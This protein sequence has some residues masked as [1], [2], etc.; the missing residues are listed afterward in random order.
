MVSSKQKNK[1]GDWHQF[2]EQHLKEI[3]PRNKNGRIWKLQKKEIRIQM[4]PVW[5]C[6]FHNITAISDTES[7]KLRF[8]HH[9]RGSFAALEEVQYTLLSR[10]LNHSEICTN[11]QQAMKPGNLGT[12]LDTSLQK[13]LNMFPQ[14][15]ITL[16]LPPSQAY[17][18][19]TFA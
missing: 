14:W 7:N 2:P 1:M 8:P 13:D 16:Q 12:F 17:Q 6:I 18:S 9:S 19:H 3:I 10:K 4:Q 15:N 11:I 5:W